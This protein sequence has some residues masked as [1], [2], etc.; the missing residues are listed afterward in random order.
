MRLPAGVLFFGIMYATRADTGLD[1]FESQ[2]RPIFATHC[3]SCHSSKA[4]PLFAGLKLDSRT[5][6]TH[7]SD[8]GPVLVPNRP[9]ETKLI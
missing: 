1:F 4:K 9:D 7:G 8:A 2:V 3:Y 6:L 5:A